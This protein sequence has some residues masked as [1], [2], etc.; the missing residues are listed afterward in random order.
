[1]SIDQILVMYIIDN[2]FLF[3]EKLLIIKFKLLMQ[4]DET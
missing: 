2:N 1:M 3:Y 4:V